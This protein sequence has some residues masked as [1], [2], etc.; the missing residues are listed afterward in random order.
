MDIAPRKQLLHRIQELEHSLGIDRE[1]Y[2]ALFENTPFPMWEEDFS[3]VKEYIDGL[4]A[5]GITDLKSYLAGNREALTECVRRIKVL[6]V[7]RAARH[8]YS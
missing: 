2:R 6:D 1:R 8:G 3:R 4:T 5:G 7:N